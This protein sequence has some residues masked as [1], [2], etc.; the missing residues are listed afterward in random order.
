[1]GMVSIR[2]SQHDSNFGFTL[3]EVLVVL[4]IMGMAF[5][6]T[7]PALSSSLS[8]LYL[9][10][11]ARQIVSDL[12][13]AQQVAVAETFSPYVLFSVYRPGSVSNFYEL[14]IFRDNLVRSRRVYLDDSVKMT[15]ATFPDRRLVFDTKGSPTAYGIIQLEDNYGHRVRIQVLLI[16]GRVQI[17]E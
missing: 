16:T 8:G 7:L 12:R 3:I 1:M 11:S 13:E 17:I 5:L 14:H 9:R 2:S 15:Q 10:M 4:V 6:I